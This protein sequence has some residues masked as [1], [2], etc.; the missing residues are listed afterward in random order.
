MDAV[1]AALVAA[2]AIPASDKH[3]RLVEHRPHRM[4]TSPALPQ[5]EKYTLITIDCYAGR[6]ID[7][8]RALYKEIVGRLAEFGIPADHI[9]ITLREGALE[10]WGV[11][12]GHAASD[13]DLGFAVNV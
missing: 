8:K 11:S 4:T 13:I 3:I 7:A 5:P 1:H 9:T 10:N 12:G 2:F 6:S